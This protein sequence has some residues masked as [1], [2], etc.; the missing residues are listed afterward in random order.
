[1]YLLFATVF[2]SI[3]IGFGTHSFWIGLGVFLIVNGSHWH[4]NAQFANQKR[5]S[6]QFTT[7]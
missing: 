6:K 3:M 7:Q 1:M 4:F 5:A 2:G